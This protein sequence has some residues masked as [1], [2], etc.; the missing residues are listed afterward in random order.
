MRAVFCPG[1]IGGIEGKDPVFGDQIIGDHLPTEQSVS[2][3]F[4]L[5]ELRNKLEP[6][7]VEEKEFVQLCAPQCGKEEPRHHYW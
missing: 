1:P 4:T 2:R 3:T 7:L 6:Y 5:E